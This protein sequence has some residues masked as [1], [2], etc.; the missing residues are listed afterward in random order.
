VAR[1]QTH[2]SVASV[3]MPAHS[4]AADRGPG[5]ASAGG[6]SRSCVPIAYDAHTAF[7]HLPD[8][9]GHPLTFNPQRRLDTQCNFQSWALTGFDCRSR[10]AIA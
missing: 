4:W 9:T 8:G 3:E 5:L 1:K 6:H 10:R 7:E 2:R